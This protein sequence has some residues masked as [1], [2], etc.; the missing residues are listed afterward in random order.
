MKKRKEQVLS[1]ESS[2]INNQPESRIIQNEIEPSEYSNSQTANNTAVADKF[3][4]DFDW[5]LVWTILAIKGLVLLFGVQFYYALANKPIEHWRG[6]LEIWNQWD[7]LRHLRLAETGYTNVGTERYDI[8][9]FP[10]YPW[11]VRVFAFVFRDYLL[12]AFIVSGV[13]TVAAG[14]SLHRLARLDFPD[15]LARNAVWFMLIFPTSYFLHINYNESLFIALAL[16]CFLAAR[17][18]YWALACFLGALLC[19]TRVNGL[20]I[21]PALLTEAFLQYRASRKWQWQWLLIAVVPAGF[22]VYLLLN[23]YVTGDAFTFL[24]VGRQNF[25]KSL[26]VPWNAI[27][28]AYND[29]WSPD[30]AKALMSGVQEF[31]F[32]IIGAVGTIACGFLLR[33]SYTVWMAGNW[34][35]FT[36]T[37]FIIGVPRYTLVMFPIYILFAKFAERHFW[38]SVITVWSLLLLALFVSKF[39]QGHWAF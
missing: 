9:G 12:S 2:E 24:A 35:I 15:S 8:F 5:S 13:A 39:V 19:M 1:S 27:R 32:V 33:S 16:G 18:Q 23:Q 21:I 3:G 4:K 37:N 28:G 6:W 10:L 7:S 29:I 11:L 20:V 30:P 34:L 26:G 22:G 36:C 38:N 17:Q 31:V 25:N 14:L